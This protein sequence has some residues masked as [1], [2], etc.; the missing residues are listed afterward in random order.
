MS[1]AAT[2]WAISQRGLSPATK[3]VLWHLADHHNP[4]FGC[5]PSQLQLA[6]DAE[7]APSTINVHLRILEDRGLIKRIR[8][9]DPQTNRALATRYILRFE[10][11]F[12]QEPSPD[13]GVGFPAEPTPDSRQSRLRNPES[14]PVRE[15]VSTTTAPSRE[16]PDPAVAR[17][18]EA[19]GPG[20]SADARE[21]IRE[22]DAVVRNW[23]ERGFDLELDAVPAIRM[24]TASAAGRT[25]RTW[26]YF[27]PLI[28]RLHAKRTAQA[29]PGKAEKTSSE[30]EAARQAALRQPAADPALEAY[31]RWIKARTI[32]PS[33]VSNS[34]RDRLLAAG[35]VTAA[36]LRACQIY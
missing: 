5:F 20:L 32:P 23:I 31:A 33:A 35:L 24:R 18:L 17:C 14:N 1:H 19:A 4:S 29:D 2:N 8:R 12:T 25:I 28:A 13:S 7:M 15:P 10:P 6:A 9:Y 34:L 16:A 3:I 21:A 11:E 36:E 27:T 30:A 22:T 26:A